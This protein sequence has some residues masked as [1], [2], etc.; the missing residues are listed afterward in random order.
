MSD[1]PIG[2]TIK[3][4]EEDYRVVRIISHSVS[5]FEDKEGVYLQTESYVELKSPI[6]LVDFVVLTCERELYNGP[7]SPIKA[8]DPINFGGGA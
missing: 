1:Y 8:L 2:H 3:H 4:K 7:P 5:L 6:G